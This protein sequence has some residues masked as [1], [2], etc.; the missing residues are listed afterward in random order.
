MRASRIPGRSFGCLGNVREPGLA[1]RRTTSAIGVE[2]T[3]FPAAR[4]SGVFVGL[5]YLVA[6]FIANGII[7]TSHPAM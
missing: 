6:A 1:V 7:A 3:G 5:M 4:Y 2:T